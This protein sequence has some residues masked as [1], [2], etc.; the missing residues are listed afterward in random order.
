MYRLD[1]DLEAWNQ[2]LDFSKGFMEKSSPLW[3]KKKLILHRHLW[4]RWSWFLTKGEKDVPWASLIDVWFRIGDANAYAPV[5]LTLFVKNEEIFKANYA[6]Q[7]YIAEGVDRRRGWF[8][9]LHASFQWCFLDSVSFQ[10]RD[11]KCA[12]YWHKIGNKNASD[13]NAVESLSRQLGIWPR[14]GYVGTFCSGNG[15]LGQP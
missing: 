15:N 5:G 14:R 12:W 10:K 3:R 7:D 11:C 8:S 9:Y 2:E 6:K 13:C 4:M 1:A